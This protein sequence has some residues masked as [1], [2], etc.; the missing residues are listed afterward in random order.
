MGYT[1]PDSPEFEDIIEEYVEVFD[2]EEFPESLV[3]D[4]SD[5]LPA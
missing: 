5:T 1:T 4:T 3:I 2:L